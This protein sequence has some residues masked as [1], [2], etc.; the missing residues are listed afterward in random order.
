MTCHPTLEFSVAAAASLRDSAPRLAAGSAG[1]G[2]VNS[3][4]AYAEVT[5]GGVL[6]VSSSSITRIS[7]I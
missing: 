4:G 6:F 1:S 2:S 3:F 5:M 7:L